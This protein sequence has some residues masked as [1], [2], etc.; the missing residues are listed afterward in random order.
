MVK[1]LVVGLILII[2]LVA[3]TLFYGFFVAL[4]IRSLFA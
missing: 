1:K 2:A 4:S 3:M